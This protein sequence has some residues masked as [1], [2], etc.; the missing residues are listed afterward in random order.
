MPLSHGEALKIT[1]FSDHP[2]RP[3]ITFI[4]LFNAMGTI[5]KHD[6]TAS[7]SN[8]ISQ[9]ITAR[10]KRRLREAEP[11]GVLLRPVIMVSPISMTLVFLWKISIWPHGLNLARTLMLD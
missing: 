2:H 6:R 7:S 8:T 5:P 10:A 4:L 9:L 11:A 3:V 1:F